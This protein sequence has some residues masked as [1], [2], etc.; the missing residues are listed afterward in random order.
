MDKWILKE[1]IQIV[2]KVIDWQDA[3]RL[4]GNPLL[5]SK[6]INNNYIEKII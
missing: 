1:H 4:C 3:I 6:I 2:D 5:K